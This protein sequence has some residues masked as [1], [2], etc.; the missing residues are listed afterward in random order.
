MTQVAVFASQRT[1]PCEVEIAQLLRADGFEVVLPEGIEQPIPAHSA[2]TL[3]AAIVLNGFAALEQCGTVPAVVVPGE[4]EAWHFADTEAIPI[5]LRRRKTAPAPDGGVYVRRDLTDYAVYGRELAF[6][7][8]AREGKTA[9]CLPLR[10]LSTLDDFDAPF[11]STE[12]RMALFGN[13]TTHLKEEI[14]LFEGNVHINSQPFA[15]LCAETLLT[16]L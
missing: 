6:A 12:M 10:G 11:F 5:H 7:L 15:S 4:A 14:R 1:R 16:L 13:L 8:N 2:E 3:D 9:V